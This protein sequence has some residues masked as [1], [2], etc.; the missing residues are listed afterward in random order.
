MNGLEG[1]AFFKRFAEGQRVA[2]HTTPE[3]AAVMWDHRLRAPMEQL[4]DGS[5]MQQMHFDDYFDLHVLEWD[6]KS[7]AGPFR[8]RT[9]RTVHHVPTCALLVEYA[10][11]TLGYSS[12][13]AF[14]PSVIEFLSSANLILHE[15]NL[16]PA[17]T[18]YERLA[19]LP[20]SLRRKMR[21]VH[22]PDG[23]QMDA[24]E[25]LAQGALL[26]V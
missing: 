8:I 7:R 18:P 3:A 1:V 24:I 17:H 21:L 4:W 15:T 16:G 6:S 9:R 11:R 20:E 10:G 14:D 22:Y 2:L 13:T 25:P 23:L 19:E 26:R 5:Q 12:D